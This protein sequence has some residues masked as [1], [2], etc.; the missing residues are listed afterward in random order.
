M[1][2][3]VRAATEGD[4][5]GIRRVAEAAWREAH[6]PI[7]GED[8]VEA[9]LDEYYDADAFRTVLADQGSVLAVA[10]DAGVV[11]F[12]SATP[13]DD[14]PDTYHLNRI[15]VD[16]DRWGEGFGRRLLEHAEAAVR[17]LGGRRLTLG[18]MAEND[19]AVGFYDAAGFDRVGEFY[20]DR[21]ETPGYTYEKG[22]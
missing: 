8:A 3:E 15:Y 14:R 11:G 16:P 10:D 19:R 18:V 2:V 12:V 6:A 1:V 17:D 13:D 7:V 21:L 5:A 20:D 9:F 22:L 4:I